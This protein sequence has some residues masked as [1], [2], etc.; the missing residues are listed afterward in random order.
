[1]EVKP[2]TKEQTKA[3]GISSEL[4]TK[5]LED[6]DNIVD[7]AQENREGLVRHTVRFST[8]LSTY[9]FSIA[10]SNEK[11]IEFLHKSIECILDERLHRLNIGVPSRETTSFLDDLLKMI[12]SISKN[13]IKNNEFIESFLNSFSFK[14]SK[15]LLYKKIIENCDMLIKRPLLARLRANKYPPLNAKFEENF[16]A[17]SD[18]VAIGDL[19][20]L[21]TWISKWI[22]LYCISTLMNLENQKYKINSPLFD[23]FL[24]ISSQ[25]AES[26]NVLRLRNFNL[27]GRDLSRVYLYDADIMGADLSSANLSGGANLSSADLSS[28]NL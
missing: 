4:V 22:L 19:N 23:L 21:L 11:R 9:F 26:A 7:I 24:I 15:S 6:I 5:Y 3:A 17:L 18:K 2:S 1:M 27:A 13:D 28:A 8:I 25:I 20:I 16:E 14:T 10:D 12:Y